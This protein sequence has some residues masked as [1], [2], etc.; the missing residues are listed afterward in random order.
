[1]RVS[2]PRAPT[3][4]EAVRPWI[5]FH[6]AVEQLRIQAGGVAFPPDGLW[7]DPAPLYYEEVAEARAQVVNACANGDLVAYRSTDGETLSP[8]FWIDVGEDL[9]RRFFDLREV[10][11]NK[12]AFDEWK[13]RQAGGF[14]KAAP[15]SEMEVRVRPILEAIHAENPGLSQGA[16][17]RELA[18]RASRDAPP[19]PSYGSCVDY[20]RWFRHGR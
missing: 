16:C 15:R 13:A 9:G 3:R 20:V 11:L 5:A 19:H 2:P 12:S 7:E 8:A 6:A 17:A 18:A 4:S 10:W 14:R 1:V